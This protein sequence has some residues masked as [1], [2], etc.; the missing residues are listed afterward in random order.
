MVSNASMADLAARAARFGVA[1]ILLLLLLACAGRPPAP[2]E[3]HTRGTTPR[4][5]GYTVLRGDTLYSIAFRYGLDFIRD[6]VIN[7]VK[8]LPEFRRC[9]AL[10]LPLKLFGAIRLL[11]LGS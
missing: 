1:A 5:E 9:L 8:K 11:H 4:S 6:I 2:I 7:P 10:L 3:D